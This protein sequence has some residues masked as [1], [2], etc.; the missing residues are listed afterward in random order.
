MTE[1]CEDAEEIYTK[2]QDDSFLVENGVNSALVLLHKYLGE[3][4]EFDFLMEPFAISGSMKS[5]GGIRDAF[6]AMMMKFVKNE[7]I[8]H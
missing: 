1:E 8:Q 4:A 6:K 7:L 3:N 2:M 5:E